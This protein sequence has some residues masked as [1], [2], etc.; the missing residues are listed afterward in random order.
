VASLGRRARYPSCNAI[1]ND[2]FDR[3]V[4]VVLENAGH[5]DPEKID[6]YIARDGYKALLTAL[7][8]M[9]PSGGFTASPKAAQGTGGGRLSTGLSGARVAKAGGELKYVSGNPATKAIRTRS[10]IRSVMDRR[11]ASRHRRHGHCRLTPWAPATEGSS[12]SG[13]STRSRLPADDRAAR[14]AGRRGLLGSGNLQ[15]AL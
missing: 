11:P 13:P 6:D 9:T 8:E 4:R 10:W 15:H 1:L 3:Q 12:M 5:I 2:H 14:H 7:T